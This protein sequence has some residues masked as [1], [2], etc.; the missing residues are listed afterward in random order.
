[1]VAIREEQLN[2]NPIADLVPYPVSIFE[3]KSVRDE[4]LEG[5][6][7]LINDERFCKEDRAVLSLNLKLLLT[8]ILTQYAAEKILQ[9]GNAQYI[10]NYFPAARMQC[11]E[12]PKEALYFQRA[13]VDQFKDPVWRKMLRMCKGLVGRDDIQYVSPVFNKARDILTFS[14]APLIMRHAQENNQHLI[15]N[16][17]ADWFTPIP[18][19]YDK[20]QAFCADLRQ[21]ILDIVRSTIENKQ[22]PWGIQSQR[23]LD[24]GLLFLNHMTRHHL[25]SL[26]AKAHMLP[27][28][29]W[30]GTAGII[31]NR[32]LAHVARERGVWVCGHDHGTGA[33]WLDT[34][35]QTLVE[36]NYIDEFYT[37][38]PLM[39][40]GLK[41]TIKPQFLFNHD[42]TAEK[43]IHARYSFGDMPKR[44]VL[45]V[46]EASARK[47]I[48]F[49][50]TAYMRDLVDPIP[51][52]PLDVALEW[53][54]ALLL[55]LEKHG[56]SLS[57]RPH[58][59]DPEVPDFM[60]PYCVPEG[61]SLSNNIEDADILLFDFPMTTAIVEAMQSDK[62]IL[63]IDF[64]IETLN[65][66]G[67][68]KLSS[69]C[70]MLKMFFDPE[71]NYVQFDESALLLALE[72]LR[73][74]I[75]SDDVKTEFYGDIL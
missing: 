68:E 75:Q 40:Q 52:M 47:K 71:R 70:Q 3:L 15:R 55:F 8:D 23:R 11:G 10:Q 62:P 41:S 72:R 17:Y 26:R 33:G 27:R 4:L 43:I 22:V 50:A 6:V 67:Q 64:D 53:H 74:D 25:A 16:H 45:G 24:E 73:V 31:Y 66:L 14:N 39:A 21:S 61:S 12:V 19:E 58:P 56:Y 42:F 63:V 1:M 32:L 7:K 9:Q 35:D 34:L 20:T 51:R 18:K 5:F 29:L 44:S 60:L 65:D 2:K 48:L 49:I 69:R 13:R 37:Y 59:D 57:V 38:T 28:T 30:I 54:K 46:Q 36:F